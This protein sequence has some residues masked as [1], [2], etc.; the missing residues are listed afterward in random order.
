MATYH[1][2][3]TRRDAQGL[4]ASLALKEIAKGL[5]DWGVSKK[6]EVADMAALERQLQLIS[7]ED[8]LINALGPYSW[9]ISEMLSSTPTRTIHIPKASFSGF[10]I[11]DVHMLP[12]SRNDIWIFET[13]YHKALFLKLFPGKIPK[14]RAFICYPYIVKRLREMRKC[15]GD[16]D[17][18]KAMEDIRTRFSAVIGYCGRMTDDKNFRQAIEAFCIYCRNNPKE[19][20]VFTALGPAEK[21]YHQEMVYEILEKRGISAKRY[22]HL[23]GGNVTDNMTSLNFIRNCDLLLFPSCCGEPSG[24]VLFEA[25]ITRTPVIAA[26]Y[27][28]SP[29]FLPRENLVDVHPIDRPVNLHHTHTLATP[30]VIQMAQMIEQ[31]E[32]LGTP[33]ISRYQHHDEIFISLIQDGKCEIDENEIDQ[34]IVEQLRACTVA[35]GDHR[36]EQRKRKARLA[37]KTQNL[38]T[39]F[40]STPTMIAEHADFYPVYTRYVKGRPKELIISPHLDDAILSLG[41]TISVRHSMGAT[42]TIC[43]V[44]TG[45]LQMIGK[46]ETGT[47]PLPRLRQQP[48]LPRYQEESLLAHEY[49]LDFK[50]LGYPDGR[51]RGYDKREILRGKIKDEEHMI[52]RIKDDLRKEIKRNR[53]R[54]YFPFGIGGHVDHVILHQIARSLHEEGFAEIYL[55][56]DMPYALIDTQ[57]LLVKVRNMR[58][59]VRPRYITIGNHIDQ[60][61]NMM[62]YYQSQMPM[63]KSFCPGMIRKMQDY[64]RR[65]S[66]Q[67]KR[68]GF[69]ER[70]WKMHKK[71]S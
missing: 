6:L 60:K 7:D 5:S 11:F 13:A 68:H 23:N 22:I 1:I 45:D 48:P 35:L 64:A 37:L 54:I 62:E 71:P 47:D 16:R 2:C 59:Y 66:G 49:G 41:G 4:G 9:A 32:R 42:V 46:N 8:T 27:G 10:Q 61:M 3:Q 31:R 36:S 12:V 67:R 15:T 28:A 26:Y 38:H 50:Y 40:I 14:E 51:S 56:E 21:A 70:V 39:D 30:D 65:M 58:K 57:D 20:A 19:K 34:R 55:Y 43:N 53:A 33:D 69:H 52:S 24:R 17:V 25:G 44:F 63:L 29:E 18:M